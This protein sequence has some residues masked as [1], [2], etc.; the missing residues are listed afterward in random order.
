MSLKTTYNL[1]TG[2]VVF[3]VLLGLCSLQAIETDDGFLLEGERTDY[4]PYEHREYT[5]QIEGL[6]GTVV[7]NT[8]VFLLWNR[9][10]SS[11]VS[12]TVYRNTVP[13]DTY[14]AFQSAVVVAKLKDKS[15]TLDSSIRSNG[16][17]YYAVTTQKEGEKEDLYLTRNKAFLERP[18]IIRGF[19]RVEPRSPEPGPVNLDYI[20]DLRLEE[21]GSTLVLRWTLPPGYRDNIHIFAGRD[22]ILDQSSLQSARRIARLNNASSYTLNRLPAN[23]LYFCI[24]LENNSTYS[25]VFNSPGN[26]AL[27]TAAPPEE[28]AAQ[29][30]QEDAQERREEPDSNYNHDIDEIVRNIYRTDNYDL[31]EKQLKQIAISTSSAKTRATAIF[32]IGRV[33]VEK[34]E[35]QSALKIFYRSDVQQYFK[36]ESRF[37]QDYCLSKLN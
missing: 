27:Y 14:S 30:A 35:Y 19:G 24:L 21:S 3:T 8:K 32:F 9:I 23:D 37:W 33:R 10:S 1:I 22:P 36:E 17:Y 2:T 5:P 6:R 18:Y 15:Q 4:S 11:N 13:L 12:Y 34:G 26:I 28:G 7:D 25:Y 16:A 29:Q 20:T 31:L